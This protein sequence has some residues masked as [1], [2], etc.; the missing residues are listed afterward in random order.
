MSLSSAGDSF[1]S[2]SW[3]LLLASRWPVLP[4]GDF[5]EV[6]LTSGDDDEGDPTFSSVKVRSADD[7]DGSSDTACFVTPSPATSNDTK[8]K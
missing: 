4:T 6:D 5:V 1:T 8:D 3:R 2:S 7:E